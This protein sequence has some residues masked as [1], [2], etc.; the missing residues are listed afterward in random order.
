MKKT[1][2]VRKWK[3]GDRVGTI[4]YISSLAPDHRLMEFCRPARVVGMIRDFIQEIPECD[5]AEIKLSVAIGIY[6]KHGGHKRIVV[7]RWSPSESSSI[8]Q[9]VEACKLEAS[10][11][12]VVW[13]PNESVEVTIGSESESEPAALSSSTRT[14][15]QQ[16]DEADVE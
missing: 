7:G 9:F 14:A 5:R 6:A 2:L 11:Y 16:A 3:P 12:K 13:P 4:F 8:E 15:A 1:E 10:K